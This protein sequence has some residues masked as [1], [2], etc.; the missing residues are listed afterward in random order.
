MDLGIEKDEIFWEL[1]LRNWGEN[2]NP[3]AFYR[4]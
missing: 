3:E 2:Q 4:S 1:G